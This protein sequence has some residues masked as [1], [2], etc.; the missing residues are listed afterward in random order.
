MTKDEIDAVI[1]SLPGSTAAVWH[2]Q[3]DSAHWDF[4]DIDVRVEN[5][6]LVRRTN[7]SSGEKFT[8]WV[9]PESAQWYEQDRDSEVITRE[10]V[11]V[12]VFS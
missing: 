4:L 12:I 2:D 7:A 8:Q 11:P 1:G 3:S 6:V 10:P 5:L 9:K